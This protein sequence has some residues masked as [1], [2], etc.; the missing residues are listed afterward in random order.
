LNTV[1]FCVFAGIALLLASTGIYGVLAYS[2]S[3][4]TSEIG[5]RV[6]L[7]ASTT[8]IRRMT[9]LQGMRPVIVG[10]LAG[11]VAAWWLSKSF[12]ALLF[13]IKP[14]DATTYAGVAAVLLLAALLAC[15]L[16]AKKAMRIDPAVALRV[17]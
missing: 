12:T 15:Y 5:L 16:P 4:R 1:G 8:S 17:G 2:M 3:R 14:F 13:G 7:G 11:T 9:L 6:A 10:L